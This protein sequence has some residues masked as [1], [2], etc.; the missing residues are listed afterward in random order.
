MVQKW[1]PSAF[2]DIEDD[3]RKKQICPRKKETNNEQATEKVMKT[4]LLSNNHEISGIHEMIDNMRLRYKDSF[5]ENKMVIIMCFKLIMN[6]IMYFVNIKEYHST[7]LNVF[8]LQL[9]ETFQS[10]MQFCDPDIPES[11]RKLFEHLSSHEMQHRA[12]QF[13]EF[14]QLSFEIQVGNF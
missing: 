4:I 1:V 7:V 12:N 10:A 9:I 5:L 3:K 13:D 2:K 11:C 14:K 8:I 6:K